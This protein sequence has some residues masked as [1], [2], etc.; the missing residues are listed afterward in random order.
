MTKAIIFDWGRTLFDRDN[1]GLFPETKAL[2]RDL[3][4]RY[5]LAIVSLAPK[6]LIETR[7]QV[8]TDESL[9]QYF[10]SIE[11]VDAKEDGAKDR[12]YERTLKHLT[13]QSSEVAIVDDRMVRGIAWGNR[14]GCT[15]IWFCNGRFSNEKPTDETGQPSYTI[16]SLDD[17]KGIL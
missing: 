9:E 17:L 11:F 5:T 16:T 7:R 15:T 1:D 6:E 13:V 8:V 2:V 4:E 12:A 10:A 3:S 14:H